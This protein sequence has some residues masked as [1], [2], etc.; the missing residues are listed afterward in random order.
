MQ[1]GV[2]RILRETKDVGVDWR[3]SGHEEQFMGDG[4]RPANS[5][6]SSLISSPIYACHENRMAIGAMS[7]PFEL[8]CWSQSRPNIG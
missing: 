3:W 5:I 7:H 1:I 8:T 6:A 4:V 2:D